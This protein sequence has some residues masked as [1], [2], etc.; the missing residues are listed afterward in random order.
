MLMAFFTVDE[1]VVVLIIS[2]RFL[3]CLFLP[4]LAVTPAEIIILLFLYVINYIVYRLS[5]H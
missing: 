1:I 2:L 5:P 4:A 3:C